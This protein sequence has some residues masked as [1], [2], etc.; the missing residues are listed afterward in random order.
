MK[1]KK[2]KPNYD[3]L[4]LSPPTCAQRARPCR[5]PKRSNGME[6]VTTWII[7]GSMKNSKNLR[8]SA[9]EILTEPT[10]LIGFSNA[11][12]ESKRACRKSTG[13]VRQQR[14]AKLK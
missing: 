2:A 8:D 11:S 10:C 14:P 3:E 7:R 12:R 9:M 5:E 13:P 1:K 6:L 4:R